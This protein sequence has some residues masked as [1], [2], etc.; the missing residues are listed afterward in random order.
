[1]L[2]ATISIASAKGGCG[3]TT[4]AIVLGAVLAEQGY[5]TR[6]LDCDLNQ[7]ASAFGAKNSLERLDVRPS[8]DEHNVLAELRSAEKEAE[9]T[10][11]DLPG[12]S[13]TLALKALQRSNFVLVPCQASLPDVRDAM[14]TIAQVDD[15]QDLAR[16]PIARSLIWSRVL[17]GFE[18]R[19][20]KHVRMSAEETGSPIFSSALMERAAFR[21][22]HITGTAPTSN[23]PISA[24]AHNARAIADELVLRLSQLAENV[25]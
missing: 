1:M 17:P 22:M 18:S 2:M 8:V 14:K 16:S 21:E 7:H 24:A 11:I 4:L 15:A 6:L 3:K 19:A 20:A 25:A 10:L 9:I 13:S 5:V 12:G 23:S